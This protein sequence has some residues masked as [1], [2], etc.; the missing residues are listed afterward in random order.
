MAD[1]YDDDGDFNS[2]EVQKIGKNAIDIIM[3]QEGIVYQKD[4]INQWS[5]TII[6]SCVKDLAKLDKKFKYAVTCIIMQNN[7]AGLQSAASSY[8]ETK[9]DGLISVQLGSDTFHCIVTIFAMSI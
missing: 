7:G 1:N 6:E 5:Q 8:W 2:E 9:K 3:K 4:K